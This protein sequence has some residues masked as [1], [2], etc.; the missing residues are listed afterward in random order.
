[1]TIQWRS[2]DELRETAATLRA[3][4]FSQRAAEYEQAAKEM[5]VRAPFLRDLLFAAWSK[6]PLGGQ[7]PGSPEAIAD[8]RVYKR[9]SELARFL[10]AAG[11]SP[12]RALANPA[13]PKD[14]RDA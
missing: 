7:T 9:G 14:P 10:I 4:G 6:A 2:P 8:G 1:M 13:I 5:E 11:W 3:D 12:P